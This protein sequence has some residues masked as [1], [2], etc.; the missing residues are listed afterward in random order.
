MARAVKLFLGT[1]SNTNHLEA[2][3][4]SEHGSWWRR[5]TTESG[6]TVRGWREVAAPKAPSHEAVYE[7]RSGRFV[8]VSTKPLDAESGLPPGSVQGSVNP[9][10]PFDPR[11]FRRV[12]P[13]TDQER[14]RA[15][16][17][18]AL[19]QAS[20]RGKKEGAGSI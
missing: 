13:T 7:F 2:L 11:E 4:Q 17:R 20:R 10:S 14:A 8:C 3:A 9:L 12:L 1:G 19:R 18:K 15:Q 16:E 5:T 6:K